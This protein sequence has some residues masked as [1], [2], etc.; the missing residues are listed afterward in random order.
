MTDDSQPL[1]PASVTEAE[2]SE[3]VAEVEPVMVT[4]RFETEM[5]PEL[6]AVLSKYVVLSRM[7]TAARNIDLVASVTRPGRFTIV[8][9]WESEED[10]QRHFD[11]SVMVEMAT[12]C[13][14]LLSGAPDIDLHE[15]VSMHDLG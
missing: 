3:D 9:K 7:D 11:G 14:G 13:T 2:A 4:M 15:A 12:A 6:L 5:V 10:Q 8:E 1:D